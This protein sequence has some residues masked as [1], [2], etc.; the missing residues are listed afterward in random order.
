LRLELERVLRL[1][2]ESELEE[3]K[4]LNLARSGASNISTGSKRP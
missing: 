3:Q 2:K 4:R 1:Q